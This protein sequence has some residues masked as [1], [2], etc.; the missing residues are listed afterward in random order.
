MS[1][2]LATYPSP[3]SRDSLTPG[4]I[5]QASNSFCAAVRD[6]SPHKSFE[7][8][9]TGLFLVIPTRSSV[10]ISRERI[11]DEPRCFRKLLGVQASLWVWSPDLTP[12]AHHV[13][14]YQVERMAV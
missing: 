10:Y 11:G 3:L 14:V 13:P 8:T 2:A 4:I 6:L 5:R 1:A 7:M 12:G 9:P